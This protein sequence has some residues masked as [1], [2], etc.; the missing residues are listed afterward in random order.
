MAL[1]VL[2]Q[3]L[4]TMTLVMAPLAPLTSEHMYLNLRPILPAAERRP[5]IHLL[6]FP[7]CVAD[8]EGAEGAEGDTR[9][10]LAVRVAWM[11]RVIVA[12]SSSC[13]LARALCWRAP[14][15]VL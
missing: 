4:M 15:L 11:Q 8:G 9:H 14:P 7:A 10:S 13:P 3:V 2:L 12:G 1:R 6:P 5:S